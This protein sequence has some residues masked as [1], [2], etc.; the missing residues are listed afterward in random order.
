MLDCIKPLAENISTQK[1]KG[2]EED[3]T[4]ASNWGDGL[5]LSQSIKKRRKLFGSNWEKLKEH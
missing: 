1:K 3:R 2:R 4:D 5:T